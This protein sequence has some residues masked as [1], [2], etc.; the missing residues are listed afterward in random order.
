[1]IALATAH[2]AK[3]PEAV[4]AATGLRPELPPHI[5]R[6]MGLKE[7][8]SLLPNDLRTVEDFVERHARVPSF[9]SSAKAFARTK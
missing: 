1:M 7:R 8:V 6:I 2:P 3:F 9:S 4:A 5:A